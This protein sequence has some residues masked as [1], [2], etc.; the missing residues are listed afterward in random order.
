MKSGDMPARRRPFE[1]GRLIGQVGRCRKSK[2]ALLRHSQK[3]TVSLN[4]DMV[5]GKAGCLKRSQVVQFHLAVASQAD[6]ASVHSQKERI[7]NHGGE[8]GR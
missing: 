5:M 4:P 6:E 3:Y 7:G 2:L 8:Y 1:A